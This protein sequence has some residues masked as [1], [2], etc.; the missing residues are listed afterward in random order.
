M[1]SRRSHDLACPA[2]ASLLDKAIE[3]IMWRMLGRYLSH[4]D[5]FKH[6][7]HG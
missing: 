7:F 2:A 3:W 4:S 6:A 5:R 1:I